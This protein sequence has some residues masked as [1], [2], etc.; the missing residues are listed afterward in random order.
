MSAKKLLLI[1][2]PKAGTGK[3][4]SHLFEVVDILSKGGFEVTVYP[5]KKQL[6]AISRGRP[7]HRS[8]PQSIF[9]YTTS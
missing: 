2:N 6:D 3:I 1:V 5:T 7:Q 4:K 9:C 8:L